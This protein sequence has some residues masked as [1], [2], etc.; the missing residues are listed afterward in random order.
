MDSITIDGQHEDAFRQ[1]I[2]DMLRRGLADDAALHL[3]T[4]LQP[5]TGEGAPFPGR[6]MAVSHEDIEISGWEALDEGLKKFDRAEQPVTSI[7]LSFGDPEGRAPKPDGAGLMSLPVETAYFSDEAFPF[8]ESDRNDLLDGYSSFGCQWA[9]DCEGVD[10]AIAFRG[11]DDLYGALAQLEQH[12]LSSET[13]DP[14]EIR[15]GTIASCYLSVL[16][17]KALRDSFAKRRMGRPLCVLTANN[18]VYPSFDAPVLSCDEYL[19]G[20]E[21]VAIAAAAPPPMVAEDSLAPAHQP[22][23]DEEG[24]EEASLLSIGIK[25]AAKKPVLALAEGEDSSS[26]DEMMASAALGVAPPPPPSQPTLADDP[27]DYR[28]YLEPQQPAVD[29]VFEDPASFVEIAAEAE[30]ELPEPVAEPMAAEETPADPAELEVADAV[31][32]APVEPA[33]SV[34]DFATVVDTAPAEPDAPAPVTSDDTKPNPTVQATIEELIKPRPAALTPEQIKEGYK[35]WA[36]TPDNERQMG[37]TVWPEREENPAVR[38]E[39]IAPFEPDL[40]PP[41][42]P[43]RE[44]APQAGHSLRARMIS[45]GEAP[46]PMPE[47]RPS[48]WS[49]LIDRLFALFQRR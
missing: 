35:P 16:F 30:E 48:F 32:S 13:P 2:E 25:R 5:F 40:P 11:V 22:S 8:S 14:D 39:D 49:K 24:A 18:G 17:H 29:D 47:T 7:C 3:R 1:S 21:V 36:V 20:G 34:V 33:Q 10:H 31:D 28:P 42:L 46:A 26:M 38:A 4:L 23:E 9:G 19:A 45:G 37:D 12:L 6:F 27:F 15:A 44:F 43:P 41:P